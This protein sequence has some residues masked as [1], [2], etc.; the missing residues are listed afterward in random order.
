MLVF[1]EIMQFLSSE[2]AL[3]ILY[4]LKQPQALLILRNK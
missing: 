3:I 4:G 1:S 2:Q